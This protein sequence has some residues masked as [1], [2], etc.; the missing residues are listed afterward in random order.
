MRFNVETMKTDYFGLTHPHLRWERLGR[1]L[2]SER[3]RIILLRWDWALDLRL[4]LEI[5]IYKQHPH[6]ISR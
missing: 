5:Y 6:S 2:F 1:L 3:L 4:C